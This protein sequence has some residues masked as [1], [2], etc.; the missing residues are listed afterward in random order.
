MLHV[1][2]HQSLFDFPA[3]LVRTKTPCGFVAKK[4]TLKLPLI[5][6]WM[7]L[8]DCVFIDRLNPRE[9]MKALNQTVDKLNEGKSMTIFPEGTRSKDGKL[10]EFKSGAFKIAQKTGVPIIPVYIKGSRSAFEDTKRITKTSIGV[11]ILSHVYT[12]GLTREDFRTLGDKIQQ[13]ILDEKTR[14]VSFTANSD[15]WLAAA[16]WTNILS[17]K[18]CFN[19]IPD[20]ILLK[21]QLFALFQYY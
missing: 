14:Q 1:A 15:T 21:N 12:A 4:E 13:M 7:S 5:R 11:T 16:R 18:C 19:L 9:A 10:G 2:N 17:L 3:Q 6:T 20:S 8:N